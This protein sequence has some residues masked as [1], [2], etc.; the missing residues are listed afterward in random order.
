MR[1]KKRRVGKSDR[2]AHRRWRGPEGGRE[3]GRGGLYLDT[4]SLHPT[5]QEGVQAKG[6]REELK[7]TEPHGGEEGVDPG[8]IPSQE[9]HKEEGKDRLELE[10]GKKPEGQRN[11]AKEAKSLAKFPH[12][13]AGKEGG[14]EGG[15]QGR[16]G[17]GRAGGVRGR[18]G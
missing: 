11:H 4:G 6:N 14:R 16:A 18:G 17:Q 8:G 1:R 3:G 12:L 7:E 15:R 9:G 10:G 13:G 5:C 2:E